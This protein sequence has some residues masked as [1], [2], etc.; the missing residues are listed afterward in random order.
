MKLG[1]EGMKKIFYLILL[2]TAMYAQFDWQDDGA[3]IRQGLHIEWQRTGDANSDGTMIYAWSDCRNGVRDVV[4]QK[5]DSNGNNAWG[6]YGIVAVNA[7]GRQEDPQLV[8][9]GAGGAYIIWMDYRDESA[10][11]GDIYAQHVL[12]NG[13][14]EWGT[15]GLALINQPG[16]QSSP[17]ICSDGQGGAYVIWA[18]PS[19]P[20]SKLPLFSTCWA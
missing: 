4:V 12:N 17:N 14:L 20:H 16:Q 8:T 13:S 6:D 3:P 19:V 11:A 5:V 2:L 9:D 7:E 18:K 15:E 1:I 10:A